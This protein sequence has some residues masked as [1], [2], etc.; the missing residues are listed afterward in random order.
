[1]TSTSTSAPPPA[2]PTTI[3]ADANPFRRRWAS[4]QGLVA[5]LVSRV[6]GRVFTLVLIVLVARYVSL[7]EFGAYSYLLALAALASI[8]TD[9]G[10]AVIAGREIARGDI[11]LSTAYRASIVPQLLT[12]T[13][14]FCLVV[15]AGLVAR[16]P[17]ATLPA[18]VLT[19]LFALVNSQF[20]LQAELLRSARRAW[21]E[22]SLQV[23]AG[24]TQLAVGLAVLLADGSLTALMAVLVVKETIAVTTAQAFLPLPTRSPPRRDLRRRYFRQGLW[25]GA[26]S[27]VMAVLWRYAQVVL[28]NAGSDDE[29]AFFSVA[30]R[31]FDLSIMMAVT[32]GI[33]IL[34]F[35]SARASRMGEE[36]DSLIPRLLAAAAAAG[37]V[38]AVV[39]YA[40]VPAVSR[41]LFGVRYD[42]AAPATRVITSG[43][44]ILLVL[45]LTTVVLVARK[46]ERKVTRAAV[47]GAITALV[48]LPALLVRPTALTA[49]V[50]T[51]IALVVTMAALVHSVVRARPGP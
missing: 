37:C 8:L 13:G 43:F 4:M 48:T 38:I 45:Q 10:I 25:L 6:V 3:A 15:A 27:T 35:L 12:G 41:L 42:E 28:S 26:S 16:G 40:V 46:Q 22:A 50:V 19:G 20:N 18:V 47:L 11:G 51:T 23:L 36:H 39:A 14:A 33:G 44:P 5:A 31:Y 1:M 9:S 29:V 32:A 21:V 7:R 2:A 49:S 30:A 24:A 34:P 17:G